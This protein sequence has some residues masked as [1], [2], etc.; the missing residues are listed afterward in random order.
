MQS[1]PVLLV[2][3]GRWG[4]NILRDLVSFGRPA[5]VVDPSAEAR[6]AA[7]PMARATHPDLDVEEHVS[8]VIVATP[9]SD[10]FATIEAVARWRKPIF[11]EKPLATRMEDAE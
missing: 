8:G 10:H 1:A 3:C 11:V 7:A 4:R 2:G 9:A 5:I 6:A